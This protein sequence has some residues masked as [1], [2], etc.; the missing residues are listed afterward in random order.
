MQ[1]HKSVKHIQVSCLTQ[2]E[3]DLFVREY[4]DQYASIYFF[5]NSKVRDLSALSCLKNVEYL[6]FY[7]FRMAKQLWD[8]SQNIGLKGIFI[9]ESKNMVYDLSPIAKAPALEELLLFSNTDQ[10]YVV[11]SLSPLNECRTLKRVMLE[12]NT[13]QRDFDPADFRHLEVFKYRVDRH[14]NF[15]Y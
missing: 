4:A 14:R 9:S 12:C 1:Y 6:L 15:R 10:K 5:Q 8:M 7:N 2:E 11:R 13:E 3:F